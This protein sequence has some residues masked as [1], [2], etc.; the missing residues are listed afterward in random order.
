MPGTWKYWSDRILGYVAEQT[1]I[2]ERYVALHKIQ[3]HLNEG[4]REAGIARIWNQGNNGPCVRGVNSKGIPY[5]SC[6]YE[7]KFLALLNN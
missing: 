4:Y 1:P 6:E 7:K 2:N 3:T 5:D